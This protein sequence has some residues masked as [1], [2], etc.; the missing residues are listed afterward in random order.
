M[1]LSEL[2][3]RLGI[4]KKERITTEKNILLVVPEKGHDISTLLARLGVGPYEVAVTYPKKGISM[5]A[6]IC[7]AKPEVVIQVDQRF[8]KK[9]P[10]VS[11]DGDWDEHLVQRLKEAVADRFVSLHHHDEFSIKDGLG[12]VEQLIKVLKA[13]R[14]SYCA[15]T[16][17]GS[18][19]GWIRQYNACRAA[20]IKPIFGMEAYMKRD[21]A[22]ERSANHLILLA[23]TEEGF[24]NII[25]IHNDAQIHGKYYDPRANWEC[26]EKWGSGIVGTS[27]CFAGEIPRFLM[28]E[29]LDKAERFARAKEVYDFYKGSFDKFFVELQIIEFEEQRELNRR[30]I[31]FCHEVDG[32]FVIACDSHYLEPEQAD[33][34]DLL[35][36]ARQGKTILD[37]M[38]DKEDV[39]NFEVRNLYYRNADQMETTFKVGFDEQQLVPDEDGI[40]ERQT[41]RRPPMLDDVFTEEVFEQA[42]ANTHRIAIECEDIK[43]DDSVKL[44]KLYDD[45]AE[46]LRVLAN[47]GFKW[48]G[49]HKKKNKQEY[50]D[51]LVYEFGIIN[52]LGWPDY[53]LVMDYIVK[54]TIENFGEWAIGYGRGC[55]HP[56]TRVLMKDGIPKFIGDVAKGDMVISDDGSVREVLETYSYD[57][58]EELVEVEV[59]DGRVVR[60]TKDHEWLVQRA[61]GVR[62]WVEAGHLKEGDELVEVL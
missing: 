11:S 35:M 27:A 57:V 56:S 21:R 10:L 41:V 4:P 2:Y 33:T 40:M 45:S 18:V 28:D 19:G 7:A 43:L 36:M 20:G 59:D 1:N 51:R 15:I 26:I 17:H 39:W 3:E 16:N 47:E 9:W 44:P 48:R 58:D 25:K 5:L 46:Q 60:C 12:T 31:E 62:E 8:S 22:K 29:D 52:K 49:L 23:N 50:V 54:W 6:E 24:Y 55:F 13:Q 37:K 53:F 34:H 32:Q 38:E 61:N 42:M 14:R 30:L